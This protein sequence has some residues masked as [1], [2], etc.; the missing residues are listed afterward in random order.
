MCCHTFVISKNFKKESKIFI[1]TFYLL[2]GHILVCNILV[3][4][5][6]SFCLKSVR[7]GHSDLGRP[8]ASA[9]TAEWSPAAAVPLVHR[10]RQL[11]LLHCVQ[12]PTVPS[13]C[14]P[15]IPR[16]SAK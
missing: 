5:V 8:A 11:P 9:C 10:T 14:F 4:K 2:G 16:G 1:E 13:A 3:S 7:G 12:F 15:R 6:I